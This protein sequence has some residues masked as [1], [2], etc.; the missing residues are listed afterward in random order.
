MMCIISDAGNRFRKS[1]HFL[2]GCPRLVK[3]VEIYF[4]N[5]S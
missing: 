4:N 1:E 5:M 3:K 2:T